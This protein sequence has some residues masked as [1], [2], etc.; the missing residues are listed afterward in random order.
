MKIA[1]KRFELELTDNY[2]IRLIDNELQT[3]HKCLMPFYFNYGNQYG[4]NLAEHCSCNV[5]KEAKRLTISFNNMVFWARFREHGYIKP[6]PGP[7]L[8]FEFSI[9]LQKNHVVFRVEKICGM[10][11]EECRIIFPN[12]LFEFDSNETAQIVVPCPYGGLIEF[13]RSDSLSF[14][15]ETTGFHYSGLPV[16][17][18]FRKSGGLGI[19]IKTP[20]D[21]ECSVDIN[22]KRCNTTSFTPEFIFE[23]ENA[24]YARELHVYPL[25]SKAGYVELAK[26]YRKIIRQEGRFIS[27]EEKIRKN[28]EVEKLVGSVIWKHNVYSKER[29]AGTKK[30]YS[31]YMMRK[32]HNIYEGLPNNWTAKEVFDKAK[33]K[34]FDR[35]CIYNTGWNNKGYDSGYPKRFPPNPERGTEKDFKAAAEYAASLSDGYI[36]SIHDN[37]LDCYKNSE[38][39]DSATMVLK[40]D[41]TIKEGGIWRG[42][43][44][45]IMCSSQSFKFAQ[46]DMPLI[47]EM[48]GR[49]SIYIDVVGCT[50]LDSCHNPAHPQGKK[51]DAASRVKLLQY[52]KNIM[53]SVATEGSPADY[54]ARTVDLGAFCGLFM[55]FAITPGMKNIPK[56]IPLW[57]LVY[58]DSVLGYISEDTY[59][60]YGQEYILYCA[61]YGMLPTQFDEVSKKLSFE[62]REAYKA[63]MLS[64]EF[65]TPCEISRS[66]DGCYH[67]TGVQKSEFSDGTIVIANFSETPFSYKGREVKGRDFLILNKK[68]V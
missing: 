1:N 22:S 57:Q 26:L 30:G 39:F 2:E 64:H 60:I 4:Y 41:G 18:I 9:T 32:N 7:D 15:Y 49:G 65:L 36:Y 66:E 67:L 5:R 8:S 48:L 3:V 50:S 24:N 43:K 27:L 35:V 52:I 29:P 14:K 19:Y 56:P 28:P 62:L 12:G 31:L 23:K 25:L 33:E 37:Y 17:G 63:E 10:N 46:R 45:Y 54:L 42:G 6:D 21:V 11:D 40:K 53:G 13:P 44:A 16:Q 34:G 20:F 51:G 55:N 47:A 59:G 58:H 68:V 61:L 38:E